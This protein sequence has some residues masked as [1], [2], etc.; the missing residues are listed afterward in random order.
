MRKQVCE[1]LFSVCDFQ[2][3]KL[4]FLSCF[5]ILRLFGRWCHGDFLRFLY[6]FSTKLRVLNMSNVSS[7]LKI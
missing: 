6:G 1:F 2:V 7:F 5:V 3:S 4:D